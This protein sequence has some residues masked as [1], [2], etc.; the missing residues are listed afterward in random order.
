MQTLQDTATN[1]E[2]T[3]SSEKLAVILYREYTEQWS[4]DEIYVFTYEITKT[5]SPD[6]LANL[7]SE[8]F[9]EMPQE[10]ETSWVKGWISPWQIR[11]ELFT[12]AHPDG[13]EPF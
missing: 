13:D 11:T 8:A 3:E 6:Q 1:T 5:G 9:K 2:A 12:P 4:E 10:E 7:V